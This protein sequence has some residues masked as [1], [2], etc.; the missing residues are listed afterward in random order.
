MIQRASL[1]ATLAL[2]ILAAPLAAQDAA[3]TKPA[4][5]SAARLIAAPSAQA[6]EPSQEDLRARF[7]EKLGKPFLRAAAWTT[8][9]DA[10]RARATVEKKLIVAYFT[11]S[12]AY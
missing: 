4:N 12:Y 10:A 6:Q 8:D 9:Y 1:F 7:G 5:P 2:P 11:R 3:A